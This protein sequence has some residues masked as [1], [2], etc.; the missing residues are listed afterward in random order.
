MA[1]LGHDRFGIAGHDR[2]SYRAFRLAMDFPQSVTGVVVMDG[3]PIFE[4]LSRSDWRFAKS[5]FHW[6]FFAQS[7]K[8]EAAIKADPDL[9]YP[10]DAVPGV[11]N[12]QDYLD[13]TRSP[14]V[15]RGMLADYRAALELD[16]DD[17]RRDKEAGKRL[18]CPLGVLWSLNDDMETLYG[19]PADPWR[20]WTDKIIL[21][22][23]IA[24][25][26]HM[27]EEA[28]DEVAGKLKLFF[29]KLS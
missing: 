1:M 10:A 8:A 23:G 3:I 15:V 2:G 16:Y 26:H 17:D 18:Q 24:S 14:E 6:F 5:W 29:A 9:W 19:N 7:E 20:D 21:R 22:C 11:E 27:A 12:K 13:A 4:A 25:G 28:P